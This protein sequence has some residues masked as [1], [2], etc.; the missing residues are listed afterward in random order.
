MGKQ[1]IRM[2]KYIVNKN[3]ARSKGKIMYE[4]QRDIYY[5]NNEEDKKNF[6]KDRI[7]IEN[8]INNIL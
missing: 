3:I 5:F 7:L 4:K 8:R 2:Q 6:Y 1:V